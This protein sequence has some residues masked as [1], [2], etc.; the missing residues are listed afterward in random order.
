MRID[1][2]AIP[3]RDDLQWV[4]QLPAFWAKA[5]SARVAMVFEG[6][7]VGYA[8]FAV[9]A[10]RLCAQWQARGLQPGDRVGY[11]G[12]NS[13]LFYDVLF[14][15]ALG[16]FVV[17]GYNWRYAAPE[18]A[19]VLDDARPRILYHDADFA[20]LVAGACEALGFSLECVHTEAAEGASLR[21]QIGTA[22][23]EPVPHPWKFDDPLVLMYTSG[24]TG[25]PKG[26]LV[27]HGALSLFRNA[28]R[29]TP[30]W[31]DWMSSDV[32]LSAMP[33]FHIAGIG[34]V[35]KG[36]IA[37]ATV[38]HTADPSPANLI[39][40]SKAHRVNRVYMVPTIIQ[41]VLDELGATGE[42]APRYDGIYYGAAPIGHLLK[43]AIATF[44]CRFFQY[45][46]MTEAATTH[47]LGP[48]EHDAA[49]P[50]LM[51]SVGRPIAGVSADVRRPDGSSCAANEPGE[52]W[53]R[54]DMLMLGY[55]H[56][57]EATAQAVVDG[58]YRTGDGGS[59]DEAGYLYLTDRLKDMIITGGE[60]VYPVE[61]E[62]ALR[63]HPAV[64]DVAVVG[65]PDPKWGEA[66]TAIVELRPGQR[67][68]FDELREH[69]KTLIAGYKCPR[70]VYVADALPR[71]PSGK[72][73]RGN[74]KR[75]VDGLERLS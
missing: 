18:L 2:P 20:P 32:I 75:S 5:D 21:G 56:R 28:Y 29:A 72:V 46:G 69:A 33:N 68:T 14:A 10:A 11:F 59:T 13:D 60:N 4:A 41:M 51:K 25:Q 36:L 19:F 9:G 35:L 40:L 45:Y 31:D 38:V 15:C 8:E 61:V 43:P 37:G 74:A 54:S 27:S 26:A 57:P 17:A 12:R 47:V 1:G 67:P 64:K 66:V 62:N 34:F 71:T 52:I 24:T 22:G 48:A 7:E 23:A 49:R 6:R 53:I 30:Q 65:T 50:Q 58:W 63:T 55:Y 73:Q 42:P 39:R 16:G 3:D 70:L 44:G